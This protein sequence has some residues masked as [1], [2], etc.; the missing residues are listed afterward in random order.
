[1]TILLFFFLSYGDIEL[2]QSPD[3]L[4]LP[5]VSSTG[6][7]ASKGNVLYH[8]DL[9]GRLIRQI[10]CRGF[11]INKI[12]YEGFYLCAQAEAGGAS[13]Y[14]DIFNGSGEM[15][16]TTSYREGFFNLGGSLW[17]LSGLSVD[18]LRQS[19]HP[20]LLRQARLVEGES[21][22]LIL[23][24]K[25]EAFHKVAPRIRQLAYNF[26]RLW[27]VQDWSDSLVMNQLEPRIY[28]YSPETRSKERKDGDKTWTSVPFVR[29]DLP[30]FKA[31]DKIF[32]LDKVMPLEEAK[33]A[34]AQW[35]RQFSQIDFFG[36]FLDQY[37]V[38]YTLPS[39]D[40]QEG[41][42]GYVLLDENFER[43]T[44]FQQING[45]IIGLYSDR[46]YERDNG[47]LYSYN[48]D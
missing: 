41:V 29:V 42:K 44:E 11:V 28:R 15:I 22:S 1:M 43:K 40:D 32:R 10:Q 17:L 45:T 46:I 2:E 16:G 5:T 23:E 18:S 30:L 26:Q 31:V 37:L 9:D 14:T 34:K 6:I 35:F 39:D 12:F 48:P 24:E 3:K 13:Y 20:F 36:R 8:W 47:R 38:A 7:L 33:A 21:G 27:V 25:G 19:P 4:F